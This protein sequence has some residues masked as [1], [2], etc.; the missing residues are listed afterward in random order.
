MPATRLHGLRRTSPKGQPFIGTCTLCGQQN[1]TVRDA[2]TTECPN[3]RGLTAERSLI[4][5]ITGE[6][7]R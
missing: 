4:E 3:Q 6:A 5:G 7:A 1:M 2:M